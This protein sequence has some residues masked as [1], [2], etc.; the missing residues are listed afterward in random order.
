MSLEE[1]QRRSYVEKLIAA[2]HHPLA[3]VR[4]RV[5]I[6]LGLQRQR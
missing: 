5:T 2:L 6:A 1:W 4:M 3:D